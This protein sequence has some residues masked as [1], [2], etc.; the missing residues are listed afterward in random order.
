MDIILTIAAL[1]GGVAWGQPDE[2]EPRHQIRARAEISFE[3]MDV[4]GSLMQPGAP[5]D[6]LGA[7]PG[8]AQDISFFRDRVAAG[9]VPLPEVFTP[10]G[11]LSEHDLPLAS[12]GGCQRLLCTNA[13]GAE[14]TIGAQPEVK[15]LV[16][17]GFESGLTEATFRRAPLNLVAVVDKSGSMGGDPIETVKASLGEIAAQLGPADQLS[18]VLYGSSVHTHLPPTR[19]GDPRIRSAIDQIAITGSTN[20]EA[21]LVHG[22]ALARDSRRSFDGTTRVMLFTDERPNTGRTDAESFMGLAEAASRDGVGMTTVGVGVQF[23]AELAQKVS[24]VRGGNLVFFG[25]TGEMRERFA[26]DFDTWVT[27]LG[28]D[29]DV[30]V[31]PAH[32]LRIAGVYGLPGDMIRWTEGGGIALHV[33]TLF[34]SKDEGAIYVALAPADDGRPSRAIR[35]GDQIAAVDLAYEPRDGIRQAVTSAVA[36]VTPGDGDEGLT[37]GA[38]LVDEVTTL[39][40]ATALHHHDNDQDGAWQLIHALRQRLEAV[41]DP[42]LRSE[43][44][45]VSSLEATLAKLAG[46][47]GEAPIVRDAVTGL[48]ARR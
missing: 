44:T 8:G 42:D 33:A 16:Q 43:L 23:G 40:R 14:A 21:G 10:E 28:Y 30:E 45:L 18:I 35:R 22:F 4:S 39:K 25:S 26:S 19:G 15:W 17:L 5:L 31:R 29:L 1:C 46:R 36:V 48:P 7:T 47:A 24:S 6:N 3:A 13:K 9:E 20:L 38:L 37:R 27:E 41:P 2:D 32:G 11:L 34:L 12:S